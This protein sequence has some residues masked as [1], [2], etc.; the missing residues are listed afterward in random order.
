MPPQAVSGVLAPWT[1][2][3]P[4]ALLVQQRVVGR[5]VGAGI[6]IAG[7]PEQL[8]HSGAAVPDA[9]GR[10]GGSNQRPVPEPR[11]SLFGGIPP[12]VGTL[13]GEDGVP[14]H[15]GQPAA[16]ETSTGRDQRRPVG[17]IAVATRPAA[18]PRLVQGRRGSPGRVGVGDRHVGC[19]VGGPMAAQQP[20][21]P[22]PPLMLLTGQGPPGLRPSRDFSVAGDVRDQKVF[23]RSRASEWAACRP[24]SASA[25]ARFGRNCTEA[26]SQMP[27]HFSQSSKNVDWKSAPNDGPRPGP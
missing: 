20:R 7:L 11:R 9:T 22:D 5:G 27:A 4:R 23:A 24:D 25:V 8:G 3:T 10:P 19:D 18:A 12:K 2:H 21:P 6:G 13:A 1:S 26:M 16:G 17:P 15:R 14:Q